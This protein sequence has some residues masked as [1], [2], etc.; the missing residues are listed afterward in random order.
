MVPESTLGWGKQEYQE[1]RGILET[2]RQTPDEA[3]PHLILADWLEDHRCPV[4]AALIRISLALEGAANQT[5]KLEDDLLLERFKHRWF[6]KFP[7]FSLTVDGAQH[8]L[9]RIE[10]PARRFL[11]IQFLVRGNMRGCL[12]L[13]KGLPT[14]YSGEAG[15]WY[16]HGPGWVRRGN[17]QRVQVYEPNPVA[18]R[19][20]SQE[21]F[22]VV[23]ATGAAPA[24]WDRYRVPRWIWNHMDDLP[25]KKVVSSAGLTV[26]EYP[27]GES[28][29]TDRGL[30]GASQRAYLRAKSAIERA[31]LRY[32]HA[33][34]DRE[35]E[36]LLKA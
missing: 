11:S 26:I 3:G 22:W 25:A 20:G 23:G 31:C 21:V 13:S 30:S 18:D 5:K 17:V 4:Q 9:P 14:F 29:S 2:L 33:R 15:F 6:P 1:E 8:R 36:K 10:C 35:W 7:T 34:A 12:Y 32:A 28:L 19:S 27:V 16:T 24:R